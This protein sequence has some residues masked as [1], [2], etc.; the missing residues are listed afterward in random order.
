MS[1]ESRTSPLASLRGASGAQLEEIVGRY[2]QEREADVRQ[3]IEIVAASEK[4]LRST[5]RV[6]TRSRPWHAITLLG[7]MRSVKAAPLLAKLIAVRDSSFSLVSDENPHWYSFPAAVALSKIGMPA[8]EHLLG[9]LRTSPPDSTA[10]HLA[11][12]TL[13]AIL[14]EELAVAAVEQYGREYADLAQSGRLSATTRLIQVGHKRWDADS[15]A[16]FSE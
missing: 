1:Q 16:D 9:V 14:T 11:A 12:T 4:T 10:F 2:R 15:A 5:N 13:E 8:V 7:E 6:E 3:L